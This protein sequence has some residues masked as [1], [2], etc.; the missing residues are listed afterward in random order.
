MSVH[1][2][3]CWKVI[4]ER[5]EYQCSLE[6]EVFLKDYCAGGD[7]KSIVWSQCVVEGLLRRRQEHQCGSEVSMLFNGST[8]RLWGQCLVE[9]ILC[10][11]QS[12]QWVEVDVLLKG[13]R[14]EDRASIAWSRFIVEVSSCRRQEHRYGSKVDVFFKGSSVRLWGQS[15]VEGLSCLSGLK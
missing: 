3:C 5:T 13:Y 8:M 11:R 12:I 7:R 14:A 9:G 2:V 4:V 6:V 15:L 1:S 10:R